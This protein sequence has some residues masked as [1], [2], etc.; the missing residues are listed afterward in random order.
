MGE[1]AK[2]K[3][4]TV[5]GKLSPPGGDGS[6][7]EPF[8]RGSP[9]G[10]ASPAVAPSNVHVP[11]VGGR[12]GQAGLLVLLVRG[13]G[14][15][16]LLLGLAQAGLQQGFDL[17]LAGPQAVLGGVGTGSSGGGPR[18]ALPQTL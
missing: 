1:R 9:G 5:R 4:P 7:E 16:V 13:L 18:R 6:R 8:S 3:K 17:L 14:V 11:H 12:A 15:Q 10:G 2:G